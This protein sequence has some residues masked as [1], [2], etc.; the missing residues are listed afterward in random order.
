MYAPCPTFHNLHFY[1]NG[2]YTP[3]ICISLFFT[4]L[5]KLVA[6]LTVSTI[7]G[8]FPSTCGPTSIYGQLKWPTSLYSQIHW[9]ASIYGWIQWPNSPYSKLTIWSDTLAYLNIRPDTLAYLNLQ[10]AT[11]AYLRT[12]DTWLPSS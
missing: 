10:S 1:I 6:W 7:C 11:V 9:P 5:G 3:K 4:C 8:T 12:L 2:Y